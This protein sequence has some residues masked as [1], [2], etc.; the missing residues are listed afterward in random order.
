[1]K[2]SVKVERSRRGHSRRARYTGDRGSADDQ[3]EERREPLDSA[4]ALA[5]SAES[6]RPARGES[7]AGPCSPIAGTVGLTLPLPSDVEIRRLRYDEFRRIQRFGCANDGEPW[8]LVVERSIQQDLT[9]LAYSGDPAFIVLV[10]TTATEIVGLVV[11]A[12]IANRADLVEIKLL[13]VTHER[14]REYIA[15]NLKQAA[16]DTATAAGADLV[17]SDVHEDNLPMRR[18][19]DKLSAQTAPDPD[20]PNYLTTVVKVVPTTS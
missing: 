19:N 20:E 7:Q 3:A 5:R 9:A 15:I 16:M 14:R 6:R 11:F 10:A 1:M 13:A 17:V 18:L 2:R 12:P 8:T 4:R